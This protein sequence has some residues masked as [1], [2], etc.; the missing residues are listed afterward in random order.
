MDCPNPKRS[1][2]AAAAADLPD[3]ALVQILSRLPIKPLCRS[4]C[5]AKG[6]RDLIAHPLHRRKLPQTL[7][8]FFYGSGGGG[9]RTSGW[10][11]QRQEFVNFI[12]M[13]WASGVPFVDPPFPFFEDLP[14]IENVSLL[15]SCNGLLLFDYVLEYHDPVFIVCN[16]ATKQWVTV[17][18]K[19]IPAYSG[20]LVK[21]TCLIF[22]P[23]ASSHFHVVQFWENLKETLVHAYSSKT[24]VWRSSRCHWGSFSIARDLASAF[25]NGKLYLALNG[26]NEHWIVAWD[27]EGGTRKII[28]LPFLK[29]QKW[30]LPVS[31][32]VGQ[33]QGRLH[34]I[35]HEQGLLEADEPIEDVNGFEADYATDFV[36]TEGWSY[37]LCIWVL[38]DYDT[39]QWELKHTVSFLELFGKVN[40]RMGYKVIAIHPDHNLLFLVQHWNQKLISYDMD[41]RE[42]RDLCTLAHGY[43][44]ITPYVPFF[45]ESEAF[46]NKE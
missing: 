6:W 41:S 29:G 40:C 25:F 11:R 24:G 35:Y 34:Y 39:E 1:A 21:H 45:L 9:G 13:L 14:G 4:K 42:V 33:S 5:V 44:S 23:A 26:R 12:N 31:D 46:E 37:E 38:E 20:Y 8:G 30:C 36:G 28:P 15:G 32:Y 18:S 43:G 27:T 19:H 10:T 2:G 3:D 22:D 7:A 16:P 17:P